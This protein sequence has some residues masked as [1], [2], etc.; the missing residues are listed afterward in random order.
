MRQER[1][2]ELMDWLILLGIGALFAWL[3][4]KVAGF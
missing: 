4:V 2:D 1:R 3:A